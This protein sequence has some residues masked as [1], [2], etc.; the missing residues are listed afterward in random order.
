M[1]SAAKASPAKKGNMDAL[2]KSTLFN[3]DVESGGADSSGG[4]ASAPAGGFL[5]RLTSSVTRAPP[6]EAA[7]G[8]DDG[9]AAGGYF[10]SAVGALSGLQKMPFGGKKEEVVTAPLPRGRPAPCVVRRGSVALVAIVRISCATPFPRTEPRAHRSCWRA[11]EA[12]IG[13]FSRTQRM[14]YFVVLMIAGVGCLFV[15][16]TFLPIIVSRGAGPRGLQIRIAR[17]DHVS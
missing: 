15:S 1:G 9:A 17:G 16:L 12:V 6:A 14:K 8:A 11:Q 2:F 3:D 5:S 13:S 7:P 4:T 10:G